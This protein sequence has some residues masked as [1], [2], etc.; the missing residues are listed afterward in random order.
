MQF[1]ATIFCI[2]FICFTYSVAHCDIWVKGNTHTH[3]TLSDGDY[4]PENA[5]K[6]YKSHGYQF[7]VLSDHYAV[8]PD[9]FFTSNSDSSF[10][11]I[12]GTEMHLLVNL[13][14]FAVH[15]NSIGIGITTPPQE[16]KDIG[17]SLVS[18]QKTAQKA[19]A[20]FQVNHPSFHVLD[21]TAITHVNAPALVE[22]YNHGTINSQFGLLATAAFEQ[23]YDEALSA[24]RKLFC[25]ASDDTHHYN[26]SPDHPPGGGFIFVHVKKLSRQDILDSIRAGNFYASTGVEFTQC[27]STGKSIAVKVKTTAG[28]KYTIKFIGYEGKLLDEHN[29]SS[30]TYRLKGGKSETYIR[31]KVVSSSGKFAWS[32][33]FWRK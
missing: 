31:V 13:G 2:I 30:A 29:G 6:W 32:Q 19:G 9:E 26:S 8:A 3:T 24:G 16:Y 18:L 1:K 12:P 4:S 22:V 5:V 33:P 25:V 28:Q 11:V 20:I 21:P 17:K 27:S 14:K 7:L 23:C 10:V 15:C